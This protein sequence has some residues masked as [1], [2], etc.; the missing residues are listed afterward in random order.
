MSRASTAVTVALFLIAFYYLSYRYPLMINSSRTSP[1]YLDTPWLLQVGKYVLVL[2]VG[3]AAIVCIIVRTV[4]A[5][6]LDH[7]ALTA[8][9]TGRLVTAGVAVVVVLALA[10]G[11]LLGPTDLLLLGMELLLILLLGLLFSGAAPSLETLWR[12]TSWFAL[13]AVVVQAVQVGLYLTTGRLPALGYAD[14]PSVR[15]G[16]LWDDPNGFAVVIALLIPVVALGWASRWARAL[17]IAALVVS[18]ALTQSL[19]GYVAVGAA[20]AITWPLLGGWGR[21][22]I[23][24]TLGVVVASLIIATGLLAL[25]VARPWIDSKMGSV[26]DH[27]D[28]L[29]ELVKLPLQSWIGLGPPRAGIE[30]GYVWLVANVGILATVLYVGIGVVSAVCLMRSAKRSTGKTRAFRAGLFA[31][32]VAF[33]IS[34]LNLQLVTSFPADLLFTLAVAIGV[35]GRRAFLGGPMATT[36]AGASETHR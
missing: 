8:D 6:R 33:L 4:R 18:L 1:T 3:L 2:M 31:F 23:F 30:S 17:M 14:S 20:L 25:P 16:S 10:R 24:V 35:F 21:R 11:I 7:S 32:V 19:T 5:R 22:K 26:F 13:I 15:F 28:S 34:S 12:T 36:A 29:A 27:L 9:S